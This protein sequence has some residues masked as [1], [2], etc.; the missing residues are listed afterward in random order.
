MLS[1]SVT[2]PVVV[3]SRKGEE[4]VHHGPPWIYKSDVVSS[5]AEPGDLVRV[6]TERKR[7]LGVALWS[8]RSLIS[9]RFMSFDHDV[10][11]E[12]AF[13]AARLQ[14]ALAYRDSFVVA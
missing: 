11:D 7:T 2:L 4:R 10:T 6:V 12:R 14:S 8:S 9:L 5:A 1:L 3:V 13:F